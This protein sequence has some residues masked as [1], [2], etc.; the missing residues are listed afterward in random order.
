MGGAPV[1]LNHGSGP[2]SGAQTKDGANMARFEIEITNTWRIEVEADSEAQARGKVEAMADDGYNDAK[3][4][5]GAEI[6][7][8]EN[9]S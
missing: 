3:D 8:V 4:Y 7:S 5:D 9:I 6:N 1:P 2:K